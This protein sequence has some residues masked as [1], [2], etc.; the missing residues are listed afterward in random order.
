MN[1]LK[2]RIFAFAKE[3]KKIIIFTAILY[4]ALVIIF[5][6]IP[7]SGDDWEWGTF[8]GEAQLKTWFKNYNGRYS[9]NLLVIL[10]TRCLFLRNTVT[11]AI[12][13]L[14][15]VFPTVFAKKK[16]LFLLSFS[17]LLV[18]SLP[19][20]LFAEGFAWSSGFCNYVPPIF[21][22]FLYIILI[23]KIFDDTLP[24]Y[25]KKKSIIYCCLNLIIGFISTMFME[26]VTIYIVFVSVLIIAYTLVRFKKIYI[27]QLFH[28]I[29]S[30]LGSVA[31]FSNGAYSKIKNGT[32]EYRNMPF[33]QEHL[34]D[35]FINHLD[36]GFGYFLSRSFVLLISVSSICYIATFLTVKRGCKNSMAYLMCASSL[37][38]FFSMVF[39]F[40]RKIT[41]LWNILSGN[42]SYV[43]ILMGISAFLYCLTVF[44]ISFICIKDT[45]RRLKMMVSVIGVP[46]LIGP[47]LLITPFPARSLVPPYL[48][49]IFFSVV[50]LDGMWEYFNFSLKAE[51]LT[52]TLFTFAI[53]VFIT[54]YICVF[55]HMRYYMNKRIEY[56]EKQ[57]EANCTEIYIPSLP[58]LSY[59]YI[60][61]LDRPRWIKA[62]LGYLG[63]DQNLNIVILPYKEFNAWAENF[64]AGE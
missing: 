26:N 40:F 33:T 14:L 11:P 12:I 31:M 20:R 13:T 23:N 60:G 48:C 21:L 44:V 50:F 39:L 15:C 63:F 49:L 58:H 30:I 47:M 37:L 62:H 1:K 41:P 19:K 51:I 59:I 35:L 46:V 9:G 27:F 61:E 43:G 17:T 55:A 5:S 7:L 36:I 10:F 18:I 16:S 57:V 6:L 32:D 42:F 24:L 4:A 22:T 2:V 52:K 38:N 3:N 8:L 34:S 28:F 29:G 45:A 53:S 56:I 64:N 25:S 54:L